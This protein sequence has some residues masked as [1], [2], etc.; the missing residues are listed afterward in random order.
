MRR[1]RTEK[2][3]FILD[4]C[5]GRK[6]LDV[7]CVNHT[8]EATLGEDWKHAKIKTSARELVGLDYEVEIVRELNKR[9]WNIVAGDAQDFD[10]TK[11]YPSGFDVIVASDMI[12]HLV[13]PGAFLKCARKH[14]APGGELIITTPHAYGFAFFL[15][16]LLTGEEHINDDHTMT[17]SRKNMLH[18]LDRCGLRVKEFIW[19]SQ[20]STSM[21]KGVPAKVAAKILF[22]LQCLAGF[23]RIG[24]SKEMIVVAEDGGK[25]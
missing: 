4:R 3:Q 10:L 18:L 21:H 15:E 12:E 13:N 1:F 6:V 9:G 20:D 16:V 14:L 11:T 8:L 24:F 23:V 7:G 19:L 22:I 17:F 5:R 2:D 25:T